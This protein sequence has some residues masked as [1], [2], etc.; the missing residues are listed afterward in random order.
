MPRASITGPL[1]SAGQA[2]LWPSPIQHYLLRTSLHSL[3]PVIRFFPV[4]PS[5]RQ[6]AGPLTENLPHVCI[7]D[8]DSVDLSLRRPSPRGTICR[9]CARALPPVAFAGTVFDRSGEP[10][11]SLART[12]TKRGHLA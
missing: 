12:G 8:R 10:D 6:A 2:A 4:P 7:S 9:L 11:L 5:T 3:Y 1:G